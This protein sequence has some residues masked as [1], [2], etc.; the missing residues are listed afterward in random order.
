MD[1]SGQMSPDEIREE[2]AER[3]RSAREIIEAYIEAE[4]YLRRVGKLLRTSRAGKYMW[5]AEHKTAVS[6]M[7]ATIEILISAVPRY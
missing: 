4:K 5:S 6:G 3:K 1:N 7:V 2:D